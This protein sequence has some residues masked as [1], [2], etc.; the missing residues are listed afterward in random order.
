MKTLLSTALILL[1]LGLTQWNV[2]Q[3]TGTIKQ[4]DLPPVRCGG[5]K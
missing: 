4:P 2:H 1:T 3:L 5:V